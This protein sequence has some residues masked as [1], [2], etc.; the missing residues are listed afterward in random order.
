MFKIGDKV[1]CTSTPDGLE[2]VVGCTGIVKELDYD[3]EFINKFNVK[4]EFKSDEVIAFGKNI[5]IWWCNDGDLNYLPKTKEE[6][7]WYKVKG[8]DEQL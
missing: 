2:E 1:L 6:E 7:F 3:E 4:V 5:L 8:G